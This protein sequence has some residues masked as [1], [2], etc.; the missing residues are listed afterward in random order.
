MLS[1]NNNNNSSSNSNK[2]MINNIEKQ[3]QKNNVSRINQLKQKQQEQ[4]LLCNNSN[5]SNN[6]SSNNNKN[7]NNNNNS[8][9]NLVDLPDEILL[10]IF[11]YFDVCSLVTIS[12]TS[13]FLNSVSSNHDLWKQLFYRKWGP[14]FHLVPVCTIKCCHQFFSNPYTYLE[15]IHQLFSLSFYKSLLIPKELIS[16]ITSSYSFR[17]LFKFR[18]QLFTYYRPGL[19]NGL[20]LLQDT[21][22]MK[23]VWMKIDDPILLTS[24][25]TVTQS[26]IEKAIIDNQP[27]TTVTSDLNQTLLLPQTTLCIRVS[28]IFPTRILK[29]L[30]N[31]IIDYEKIPLWDVSLRHCTGMVVKSPD[32]RLYP[33][34]CHIN[35]N[36]NN[37]INQDESICDDD[38]NHIR[39]V[40]ILHKQIIGNLYMTYSRMI[41]SRSDENVKFLNSTLENIHIENSNDDKDNNCNNNN[42]SN[43]NKNNNNNIN[44][45]NNKNNNLNNNNNNGEIIKKRKRNDF[46]NNENNNCIVDEKTKSFKTINTLSASSIKEE[47]LV[48]KHPIYIVQNSIPFKTTDENNLD[49]FKLECF[50][51][52]FIFEPLNESGKETKLTYLLQMGKQDWMEDVL[53]LIDEMA[54]S[55]NRSINS[56]ISHAYQLSRKPLIA[57]TSS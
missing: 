8:P 22:A 5:N 9:T 43:L 47:E 4:Q 18:S 45:I 26:K 6:S 10:K 56:L 57:T 33:N 49:T 17:H 29:Q 19:I 31:L 13:N 40:D 48:L 25:N 27:T 46:D 55:R 42:N 24:I 21:V 34:N 2:D 50:G 30:L 15:P 16:L 14:L 54:V 3:L 11:K 52:G 35:N 7:N 37:I 39:K 36:N 12:Q 38:R 53:E 32:F 1:N 23:D 44:N 51:S 20:Q 28:K 41:F